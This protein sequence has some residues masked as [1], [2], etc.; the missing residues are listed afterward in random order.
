MTHLDHLESGNLVPET[1]IECEE[2]LQRLMKN[3]E[4][5]L[6]KTLVCT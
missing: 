1:C 6:A 3:A 5:W 4:R 2:T